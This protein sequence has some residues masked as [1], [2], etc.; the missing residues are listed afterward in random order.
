[1]VKIRVEEIFFPVLIFPLGT[2]IGYEV[3]YKTLVIFGFSVISWWG[4]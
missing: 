2:M 1:M 3:E 4:K